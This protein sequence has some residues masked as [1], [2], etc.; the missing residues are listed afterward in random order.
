LRKVGDDRVKGKGK[1]TVPQGSLGAKMRREEGMREWW[2]RR[3]R[4]RE[5]RVLMGMKGRSEKITG[6][7]G[8]SVPVVV[9]RGRRLVVGDRQKCRTGLVW[10]ARE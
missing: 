1:A 7:T 5:V 6:Q 9:S 2:L 4:R 8:G 10:S 3:R